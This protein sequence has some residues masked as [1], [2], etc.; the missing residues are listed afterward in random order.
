[1]CDNGQRTKRKKLRN[2]NEKKNKN[3][4]KSHNQI[5]SHSQKIHLVKFSYYSQYLSNSFLLLKE[6][7]QK[8]NDLNKINVIKSKCLISL[9]LL[10][11]ELIV[12]VSK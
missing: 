5:K 4:E 11:V 10:N 1:M 7:E 9:K 12:C 3:T 8:K 2:A 6:K